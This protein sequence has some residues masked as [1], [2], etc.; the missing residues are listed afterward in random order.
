VRE[1][2]NRIS[3]LSEGQFPE[4]ITPQTEDEIGTTSQALNNLIDRIRVA[5]DFANKIGSGELNTTY[6]AH[7]SNDVLATSLQ[8][9][10]G[11]L[12]EADLENKRR[13]WTT[14]GLAKFGELVRQSD[15]DLESMAQKL[16]SN[17]VKYLNANQGQ[18][19]VVENNAD[20]KEILRLAATYAW[21][22]TKYHKKLI[23]KGDGLVGQAWIEAEKIYMTEVP[24]D[25]III[26]SGTGEASPSNIL[27]VPMKVNEEIFGILEIASFNILENYQIEFVEKLG[28]VI[29]SAL[30]T[31]K[32]NARTK[33]L[34][35]ESQQQAEELRAQEEAVRQNQEEMMA[36]Q[37]MLMASQE[38]M[39]KNK[40]E[41][42]EKIEWLE[43]Q[44]LIARSGAIENQ[45]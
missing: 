28:E 43:S 17:L 36:N 2:N 25:Y 22:R 42:E 3:T 23:E 18:I 27:I 39:Q 5:S 4:K 29:A 26:S 37:E 35:L 45:N 34:L 1:I 31:H 41:L 6:D 13:N 38:E 11:K 7:F 15:K 24:S 19:Y 21:N 9:M 16:I 33:I 12:K 30:S 14:A 40:K 44:L 32:I 10:H 20:D 8:N